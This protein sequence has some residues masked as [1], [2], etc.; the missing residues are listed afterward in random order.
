[1]EYRKESQFTNNASKR[2][3][4]EVYTNEDMS[5]ASLSGGNYRLQ[6]PQLFSSS[7]SQEKAISIRR[8]ICEPK[9]HIFNLAVEYGTTNQQGVYTP[10]GQT[11]LNDFDFTANNNIEEIIN[12]IVEKSRLDNSPNGSYKLVYTY[13]KINGTISIFAE[14]NA[15]NPVMFRFVALSYEDYKDFWDLLNQTGNP[16]NIQIDDPDEYGPNSMEP[17]NGFF[18]QNVWSREPLYVHASF[19]SSKKHYLCRT[20]DFWFKPSKYYYD[21]VNQNDFEIYFT[22]DGNKRIIPHDAVKIIELCFILRQFSRL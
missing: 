4:E 8:V 2:V 6:V 16:F 11:Q 5:E 13:N 3:F 7:L 21:N 12:N 15:F 17:V 18:F 9:P 1:M 22:T 14:D 10:I 20:G 19:S